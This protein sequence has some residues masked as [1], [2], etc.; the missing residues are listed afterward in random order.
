MGWKQKWCKKSAKI[1]K[2]KYPVINLSDNL[3]KQTIIINKLTKIKLYMNLSEL[4][5]N[6]VLAL[7]KENYK[8]NKKVKLKKKNTW[9]LKMEKKLKKTQSELI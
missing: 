7:Q 5:N 1:K 6:I 9:T 8:R 3:N 2:S 4:S